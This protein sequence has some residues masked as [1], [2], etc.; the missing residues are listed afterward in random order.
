MSSDTGSV[1]VVDGSEGGKSRGGEVGNGSDIYFEVSLK[2]LLIRLIKNK[3]FGLLT[4][5]IYRFWGK[6]H[7]RRQLWQGVR[8]G[9]DSLEYRGTAKELFIGFLIA[10]IILVPIL[11]VS[12]LV[13]QI[14]SFAT[15]NPAVNAI[16]QLAYFVLLYG[17]WQF[18]RYRLWRYRLSRTAWRGIRFYLSGSAIRY[19][20]NVLLRSFVA[21]ITLGW[22]YP[23]LQAYR[24]NYQLNNTHFGDG[25]FTYSGSTGDLYR[26]YWPA[27]LIAQLVAV[28]AMVFVATSDA[29]DLSM[30]ALMAAETGQVK[31]AKSGSGEGVVK[32]VLAGVVLFA[33]MTIFSFVTRIWEFRYLVGKTTFNGARFSSR[34]SVR[35]V[36]LIFAVMMGLMLVSLLVVG[37]FFGAII[38]WQK[39][40]AVVLPFVL[41][42]FLLIGMDILYTLFLLVP[43]VRKICETTEIENLDVFEE[44]AA[45]SVNSPKYGEGFAD[46]MDVGAF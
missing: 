23:W 33:T 29:I 6:T 36:L 34:L 12:S 5:G 20:L 14:L 16:G 43:I 8:I 21:L 39:A 10:M 35:S 7:I 30:E 26:L 28:A 1:P 3:I 13:I 15:G 37:G 9:G 32:L 31:T 42:I 2:N 38:Y 22:A 25:Q 44:T 46:A 45:S 40:A 4:F 27:I 17:F 19:A 11:L 18:A 24:L 41:F